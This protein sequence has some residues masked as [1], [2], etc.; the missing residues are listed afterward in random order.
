MVRKKRPNLKRNQEPLKDPGS[1]GV[2]VVALSALIVTAILYTGIAV[3]YYFTQERYLFSPQSEFVDNPSLLGLKYEEVNLKSDDGVTLNAWYLPAETSRPVILYCHGNAGNISHRLEHLKLIHDLGYSIFIFD[4]RGYGKSTGKISERGTYYDAALAWQY[5]IL[6]R[7]FSPDNI[8][9][10]GRSL[11]ASVAAWLS[12]RH[13][14][15]ALII[16]SAFDSIQSLGSQLYPFLPVKWLTRFSYNTLNHIRAVKC[17]VLVIHS[18]EDEVIPYSHGK[19]LYKN[20]H[21]EKTFLKIT[22]SH[23][24]GFQ[25]SGDHYV[26]G[27]RNFLMDVIPPLTVSPDRR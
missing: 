12:A 25:T 9:V 1:F 5:L 16:E 20:I 23:N 19:E 26:E 13:T 18:I 14:P 3:L 8:I 4:Y 15:A 6:D 10:Y 11:G 27:I 24:T 17:P 7:K 2:K 21:G 22:G